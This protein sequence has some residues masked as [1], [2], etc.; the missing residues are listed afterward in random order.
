M[1]H[2]NHHIIPTLLGNKPDI[3]NIR[4]GINDV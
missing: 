3:V 1:K 4:V 2:M